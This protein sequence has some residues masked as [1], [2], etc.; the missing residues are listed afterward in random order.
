MNYTFEADNIYYFSVISEIGGI[1]TFFYQLAKKYSDRNLTIIYREANEKQLKRLRKYV[2]CIPYCGQKIKCKKA[3]FNFNTDIINDVE[4]EEY[5]LVIHGD[6]KTMIEQGQI[7]AA[8]GH[9]KID[10]YVGVSKNAC[11]AF[12]KVTGKPCEL[13]YN[14]I[15]IEEPKQVLNLISATRLTREKGKQRMELFAKALDDA[16]IPYLWTVFTNDTNA[17]NN[18]NIIFMKPRLDISN[19]IASADYL[20]QLSDNEG[21]CYSVV[22]ALGLGTPVI[23]TPCPVFN[24]I[25]VVNK[26]NGYILPFDMKDFSVED[27][28]MN[29]PK[30]YYL[31]FRDKWGELLTNSKS[32]YQN[33]KDKKFKVQATGAYRQLNLQ[34]AELKRIPEVG[35]T[36]EVDY[37]RLLFLQGNNPKLTKFVDLVE[38]EKNTLTM[39]LYS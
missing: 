35:E 39:K 37:Y 32:D 16:G 19:Y 29:I 14:P 3:F 5:I 13:C 11:E 8:P 7:D 30:F 10:K 31:P 1:E 26:K 4:A 23:V 34:D 27:I 18:P 38:E 12:T 25:G 9:E 6:Y 2:Q 22:E 33:K 17:I 15:E 24:E 21:Y 20:V 28:Y 36:W